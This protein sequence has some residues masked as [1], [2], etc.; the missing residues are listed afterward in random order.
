MSFST[1]LK[2][3]ALVGQ[4]GGPTSAINAT[5]SGVVKGALECK[6]IDKIYGAR[7]GI[8][9]VIEEN[10][11]DIGQILNT[12][13]KLF[14]LECTPAAALGS[15]RKKLVDLSSTEDKHGDYKKIFE[16]FKKYNIRYF[17]YIGGNDSM[18]TVDKLS[19]YAQKIDYEIK[20]MGVPKTIDNDLVCTDHTPGFGSAA[21]FIATTMQEIARDCSIYN[22]KA[23]TIVEIMG[24]DAGWLTAAAGLPRLYG[25]D[26]AD[27]IYLP[28]EI[29]DY[30]LFIEDIKKL[31]LK[32]PNI[33]VAVSEGIKDKEGRYVGEGSQSGAVD[34]FGH[35]YLAGTAKVLERLV[36]DKIGCKVRSIELSLPQRCAGHC[37]SKCDIEESVFIGKKSVEKALEI[38]KN[39][40][41]ITVFIRADGT[42]YNVSIDAVP[43]NEVANK[44][45]IVP[46]N[47]I[48]IEKNNVT[49]EL[50]KYIA[51][52][53]KGEITIPM[54]NGLPKHFIF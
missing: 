8:N 52:L 19:K 39:S 33:V 34:T 9:G 31:L 12:E 7:N 47:Y 5:L 10:L 21:K 45:K 51:P 44:I 18:D 28:E 37:I 41:F 13:E 23:V 46:E 29:F 17:F 50:L 48:N 49:E 16:I 1:Y 30:D 20:L 40:G 25:S 24:R 27:F 32:K 14:M 43:I 38:E 22:L 4:S 42:E 6:Y 3:N 53:I 35:K 36:Q 2:G 15:C 54:V 11:I 26:T